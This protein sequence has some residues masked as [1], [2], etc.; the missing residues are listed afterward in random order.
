[1][2]SA[3]HPEFIETKVHCN[4]CDTT[5]TTNSTVKEINVEICSVCHPFYTGKQKLVDTAGRVDRFNA[6]RD[7]AAKLK[8]TAKPKAERKSN[9]PEDAEVEK[10]EAEFE[11]E[12]VELEKVSSE[13][14]TAGS[15]ESDLEATPAEATEEATEAENDP[16]TEPTPDTDSTES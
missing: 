4:G 8:A 9:D 16:V 1:M 14:D 7:Q 12:T 11:A 3:I 5:F 15:T 2:K 6:L 13:Q 10:I